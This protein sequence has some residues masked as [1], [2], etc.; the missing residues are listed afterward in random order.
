M[1]ARARRDPRGRHAAP[2]RRGRAALFCAAGSSLAG[3]AVGALLARARRRVLVP[4]PPQHRLRGVRARARHSL[5]RLPAA[6][7]SRS[8]TT[9]WDVIARDPGAVVGAHA[10]QRL[11]SPAARRARCCSAGRSRIARVDRARARRSA[12]ARCAAC[13]RSVSRGCCCSPRWCRC[14]TR[15]RYSLALLPFYAT[16]AASRSPRRSSRSRW[17]APSGASGSSRCS[18]R[19]RSRLASLSSSRAPGARD[20]SAAGRGARSA[21]RRCAA[22]KRPGDRVIA[23]KSAHRLPRRGRAGRRSRSPTTLP[24]LARLR[25]R[26][27]R[28]LALLLVARGRDAPAVL[29]P[30]RHDGRRARAHAARA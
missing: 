8:S 11:G 2:S 23:R 13:G 28:A 20:R 27:R 5:G 26:A 19:S 16:L 17:R 6:S 10:V 29:V 14:S 12:T 30:A 25:A 21:P 3:R 15:E 22:L 24:E 7:S 1:P 9:L 18:S 4:A